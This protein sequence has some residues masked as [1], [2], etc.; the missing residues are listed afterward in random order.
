[1]ATTNNPG[2]SG[3]LTTTFARLGPVQKIAIG[4]AVLTLVGGVVMLSRSGQSVAMAPLYT[5]LEPR[6]AAAVADGLAARDVTYELSDGGR[7]VLVPRDSVYDMRV[8]LSAD[9]LPSS[10]EGYALLD[11]QG[12]TTSEFRQRVDY[13]RALEGELAMT[14]EAIDGVQS[15]TVHLA[16]PEESVFVDEPAQPTASVLVTP[17]GNTSLS[18]DQVAAMVHLVASSVKDMHPEDV[19]IAD[20]AGNVLASG[21]T[22]AAVTGT[23]EP[24]ADATQQFEQDLADEL[25]AMVGRITGVD[26]VAVTVRADLD[27]T[28][29]QSTSETFDSSE[30]DG[31]VVI[32]ERTSSETYT[33][34]QASASTGVLGPDG[35]VVQP[36]TVPAGDNSYSKDDAE[37]TYAINRTVESVTR[38]PGEI[39]RL[40]VAVLVDEAVVSDEQVGSI[41]SL[42]SAAA[43]VDQ[44]RGDQVVVTRLAFDTSGATEATEAAKASAAAVAAQD[45]TSLIR[46]AA[47]ALVTLIA[48]VLAFVSTRKARREVSTPIDIGSLRATQGTDAAPASELAAIPY[49]TP[50][51]EASRSALDE[52]GMLA[53][54][55][56]DEVALILQS[57]LAEETQ[58]S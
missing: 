15:A 56:P 29:R 16:L 48:V 42:V 30:D 17:E 25:R 54:R 28:S 53:D 55:K 1:M 11:R 2:A 7:T 8:A 4:A 58:P 33:G 35:A 6:D 36:S 46:T 12:I 23:G 39:K 26:K 13:Q 43:G 50:I 38:I 14:L 9:G 24:R 20:A 34:A 18:G 41:E 37:R 19:T 32:A 57:W 31:G 3:R 10:N 21:G 45:R 22:D 44:E 5:D 40:N 27:L 51:A 49:A 47:I 52:L